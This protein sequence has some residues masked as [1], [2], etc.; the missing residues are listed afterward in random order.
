MN[1][2]TNE[3]Q[4]NFFTFQGLHIKYFELRNHKPLCLP[5]S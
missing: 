1:Y 5:V 2:S 4:V 3:P